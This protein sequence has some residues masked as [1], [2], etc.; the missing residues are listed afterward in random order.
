LPRR[1]VA[2]RI[3]LVCSAASGVEFHTIVNVWRAIAF[4]DFSWI[5]EN[6][7]IWRYG[8]EDK[9]AACDTAA[10]PDGHVPDDDRMGPDPYLVLDYRISGEAA[11]VCV[12]AVTLAQRD[13]MEN[14]YVPAY[15]STRTDHRSARVRQ[16][17]PGPHLCPPGNVDIGNLTGQSVHEPGGRQQ[18][19]AHGWRQALRSLT[20]AK[21]YQDPE[22]VAQQKAL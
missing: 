20:A 9:S 10:F 18:Q 21:R 22:G 5:S 12:N 2:S 16:C 8:P 1:T 19:P 7:A 14:G 4:N 17:Q 3:Q 11:T 6:N 13:T 15:N